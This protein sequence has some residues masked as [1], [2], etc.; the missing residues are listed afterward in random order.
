M[1][2][3]VVEI[4]VASSLLLIAAIA[5]AAIASLA[6]VRAPDWMIAWK[7]AIL[8][9]EFGHWL[10]LL[11]L[12]LGTGAVLATT[13]PW[14]AAILLP[15]AAAAVCLLRPVVSARR[16]A[17][18][19][20]RQ[21]TEAFG[22]RNL[23]RPV[24]SGKRLVAGRARRPARMTT[25]V[26]GAPD[27]SELKVDLYRPATPDSRGSLRPCVIVIHGGGWNGGDRKQLPEWND[28]LVERG[29]VVAAISYRLAP[30]W[31]WPAQRD[32]VLEAIAWI[33]SHAPGYGIDPTRLIL[34]GRSAGGQIASAVG[35]GARD[36]AIR[37]VIALYAPHDMPFVW[38][39][40]RTDDVLNSRGLMRQFLGGPPDQG[41]EANYD[42]ASAQRLAQSDSPPTLL[43]HGEPDTLSW[44]KHGERLSARLSELGV[45]H[46]FLRLP[47][48]THA[49]DFNPA[50]PGSQLSDYA[51]EWFLA[52]VTKDW[53]D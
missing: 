7:L 22:A 33:K 12:L 48:A 20:P 19:L 27:G 38:A 30:R 18:T 10:V 41:R 43:I 26:V 3:R 11:P 50:G 51:M 1:A 21:L 13:G 31:Q 2:S 9:G 14:R 24:F 40:S 37:G 35:Y 52:S 46:F 16:L 32:D 49:F 53:S 8:A 44:V 28:W 4:D 6:V 42:S 36:P 17:A 5:V 34:F 45:P 39:V 47:W 23:A 29:C 15:C 25:A